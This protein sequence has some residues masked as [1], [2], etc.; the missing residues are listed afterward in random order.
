MPPDAGRPRVLTLRCRACRRALPAA[1][2]DVAFRCPQCGRGWEIAETEL[3]ERA[4]FHVAPPVEAGHPVLYLPYWSFMV[5][6][7]AEPI[8]SADEAKLTARDRAAATRRAWVAAYAIHRPSYVGEWGLAYTR[9]QP[10][11]EPQKGRGPESSGAATSSHDAAA[12]ARHYVLAEIDRV[13]DLGGLD[14]TV[15]MGEPELWAIPCLDLGTQIR[16]PWTR[17]ELPASALDDLSEIRRAGERLE[18]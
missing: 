4:S 12:I 11:W 3:A 10:K 7:S 17:A 9:I 8:D 6:A 5:A 15:R 14:V 1:S 16:C 2:N 18:A 13:A